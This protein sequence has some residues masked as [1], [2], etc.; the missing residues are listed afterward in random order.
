MPLF[1]RPSNEQLGAH[2]PEVVLCCPVLQTQF[3]ESPAVIV[4]LAGLKLS[5]LLGPTCTVVVAASGAAR[6]RPAALGMPTPRSSASAR[7]AA[8][9]VAPARPRG[10]PG[11]RGPT[12]WRVTWR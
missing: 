9:V 1:Q 4:T 2:E 12:R 7:T 5:E 10:A 11:G 3:T 8:S 6:P